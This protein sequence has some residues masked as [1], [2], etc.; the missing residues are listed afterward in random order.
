MLIFTKI[1]VGYR[2]NYLFL[3]PYVL[4]LWSLLDN[5]YSLAPNK[6]FHIPLSQTHPLTVCQT[7][8][9]LLL[10]PSAPPLFA[11]HNNQQKP[12]QPTPFRAEPVGAEPPQYFFPISR[13]MTRH[14][15]RRVIVVFAPFATLVVCGAYLFW[16]REKARGGDRALFLLDVR[17]QSDVVEESGGKGMRH[18]WT[19]LRPRID[20]L[21][22][23][24][25]QILR[26]TSW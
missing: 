6:N 23:I 8:S 26:G 15:A 22:A 20:R 19:G 7:P 21:L 10:S 25:G 24:I 16:I 9:Q 18:L 5:S 4:K 12:P 3:C 14:S 17:D 2:E 1:W 11:F 13:S